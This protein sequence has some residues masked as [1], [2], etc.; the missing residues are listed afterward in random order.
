MTA[1]DIRPE[2][3]RAA[4]EAILRNRTEPYDGEQVWR[5]IKADGSVIQILPYYTSARAAGAAS[6]PRGS[7]RRHRASARRGGA[8]TH[9][10]LPRHGRREH[11]GDALRADAVDNR[12]LLLNRAGEE[13]LGVPRADLI[14]GPP[15]R[16]SRRWGGGIGRGK[17]STSCFRRTMA[18]PASRSARGRHT[19]TRS[20]ASYTSRGSLSP[21]RRGGR[22]IFSGSRRMYRRGAPSRPEL[23]IC[24]HTTHSP[25][26]RT[27]PT[28]ASGCAP[29]SHNTIAGREQ[30]AVLCLDLDGFKGV[31]D[32]LGTCGRR[33]NAV[34][35]R[36][37]PA[38]LRAR[39]RHVAPLRRRRVR[40]LQGACA[41][42][43]RRRPACC[44]IH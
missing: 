14:G 6:R 42:A 3:D 18:L 35:G 9:A 40:D 41:L 2:A 34:R 31:N 11:S 38:A 24:A 26:C 7:D 27:A 22:N 29:S 39:R 1:L 17:T 21:M 30:A 12:V 16:C 15:T 23:P 37:S 43:G 25:I 33:R 5:H 44:P 13:L 10:Q 19:R 8:A 4:L 28:S 36:R 32:T 20:S